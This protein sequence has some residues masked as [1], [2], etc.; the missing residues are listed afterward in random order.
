MQAA[1]KSKAPLMCL[2]YALS[3]E[4]EN[5]GRLFWQQ[6][7]VIGVCVYSCK[8]RT[9]SEEALDEKSRSADA[10]GFFSSHYALV[11]VGKKTFFFFERCRS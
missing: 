4:C 3:A 8:E 7:W 5:N 2:H 10:L 11:N 9:S 1:R 6:V